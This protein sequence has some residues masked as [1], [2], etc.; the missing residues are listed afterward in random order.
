MKKIIVFLLFIAS[1]AMIGL[2]EDEDT[3]TTTSAPS[4]DSGGDTDGSACTPA[5]TSFEIVAGET[6][7]QDWEGFVHVVD[8]SSQDGSLIQSFSVNGSSDVTCNDCQESA[9]H[10]V[11]L[12]TPAELISDNS[13]LWNGLTTASGT[14]LIHFYA[15]GRGH[16][17]N[18]NYTPYSHRAELSTNR[19]DDRFSNGD[20]RYYSTKVWLPSLVW[21]DNASYMKYTAVISQWKQYGNSPIFT[22][23]L[24][25]ENNYKLYTQSHNDIGVSK[26]EIATLTPN[27]WLKL[28]YYWKFSEGTDGIFQIYLNGTKIYDYSGKTMNASSTDGYWKFGNYTQIRSEKHVLYDDIKISPDLRCQTM[29]EWIAE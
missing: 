15:D 10:S 1:C 4:G 19:T 16:P 28:K 17:D 14:H 8:N 20:E 6:T 11:R 5:S 3:T 29:A 24:D 26:T 9:L 2:E 25:N 27:N 7:G 22:I 18:L 13:T 21:D 23:K 12:R